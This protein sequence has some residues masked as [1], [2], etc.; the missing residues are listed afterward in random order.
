M[1]AY[2]YKEPEV[3]KNISDDVEFCSFV[4]LIYLNLTV[5]LSLLLKL[6]QAKSPKIGGKL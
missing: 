6:Y 5:I 2:P 1:L 4:M 3:I